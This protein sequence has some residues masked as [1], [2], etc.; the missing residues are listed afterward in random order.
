ML[1]WKKIF[2]IKRNDFPQIQP[3]INI[4]FY[5]Q[6]DLS[7]LLSTCFYI[8]NI[9]HPLTLFEFYNFFNL[10]KYFT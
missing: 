10:I 9:F 5:L 2:C 1:L 3:K 8:H 6:R 7:T 4:K